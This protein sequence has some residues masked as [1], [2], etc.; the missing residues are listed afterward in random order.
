MSQTDLEV[1]DYGLDYSAV[2]RSWLEGAMGRLGRSV[3]LTT[4]FFQPCDLPWPKLD[5]SRDARSGRLLSFGGAPML[6]QSVS[7]FRHL[8]Q[9]AMQKRVEGHASEDPLTLRVP[10]CVAMD[11]E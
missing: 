7:Y 8:Q 9:R 10:E 2:T 3:V 5:L 4:R 1:A 6:L 11:A